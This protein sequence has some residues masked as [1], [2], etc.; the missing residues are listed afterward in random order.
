[1]IVYGRLPLVFAGK[2]I[3]KISRFI[4]GLLV[5]LLPFV[6]LHE[7]VEYMTENDKPGNPDCTRDLR[8]EQAH[9]SIDDTNKQTQA[10]HTNSN[11][12]AGGYRDSIRLLSGFCLVA[13]SGN[14]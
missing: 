2:Q 12:N 9:A 10:A 6:A 8:T 14:S 3:N 4:V 11:I 7:V 5:D 13:L 1:M